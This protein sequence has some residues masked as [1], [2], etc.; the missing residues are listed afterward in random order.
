MPTSPPNTP[1]AL[2]PLRAA[3]HQAGLSPA[4]MRHLIGCGRG[5]VAHRVGHRLLK[6]AQHDLDQWIERGA[7]RQTAA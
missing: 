3:A 6:V 7:I 5:P 1:N 2:L 4:W